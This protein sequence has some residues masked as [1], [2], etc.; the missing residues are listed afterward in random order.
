MR[1]GGEEVRRRGSDIGEV[2][3]PATGNQNF[4]SGLGV[5]IKQQHAGPARARCDGAHEA[6]GPCPNDDRVIGEC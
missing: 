2:A 5:V 6:S 3:T 1:I 4:R